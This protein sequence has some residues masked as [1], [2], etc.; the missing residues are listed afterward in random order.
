MVVKAPGTD[1]YEV[2][3]TPTTPGTYSWRVTAFRSADL[4]GSV[5]WLRSAAVQVD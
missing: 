1:H 3:D 2:V 4:A 5:N